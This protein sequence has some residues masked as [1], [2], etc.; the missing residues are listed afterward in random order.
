MLACLA[1]A[2]QTVCVFS[3]INFIIIIIPQV[4]WPAWRR[5]ANSPD[6]W[7]LLVVA[8]EDMERWSEDTFTYYRILNNPL[9]L[10]QVRKS[11]HNIEE[12]KIFIRTLTV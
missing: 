6:Q 4:G 9:L 2:G 1:K 10:E 8:D 5:L 11:C 7:T 3:L 12:I